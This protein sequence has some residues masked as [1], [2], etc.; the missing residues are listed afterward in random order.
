M[1]KARVLITGG[2]GYV[3]SHAV[4][5]Y[6]KNN[7][8]V[9]VID[10][11]IHGHQKTIDVLKNFGELTFYK[12]DLR[13]VDALDKIFSK[14]KGFE[15]VLHFAALCSVDDSVSNPEKYYHNNVLGS[16]NLL[17]ELLKNDLNKI[18][19]SSTCAV[20]GDSAYLPIDENHPTNPTNPYGD[21]KLTVERILSAY[22]KAYGLSSVV[23]RYFNVCG[24]SEEGIIGDAKEPSVHLMQNAV[25][26]ALDIE[27]FKLTYSP[28]ET[29]DRS[30]IRDYLDVID[31]I[32]A[33]HLAHDYLKHNEGSHVFNLGTGQGNS[34][35]EIVEKVEGVTGR[36]LPRDIGKKREGEYAAV[37]ADYKK[38]KEKLGWEPKRKL[39]DSVKSLVNWY[40]NY[41]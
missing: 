4:L 36:N 23:L 16:L 29:K 39:E 14:E 33:H 15:C 37:Y 3:G 20:Y 32:E 7:Y 2:A 6:L 38:V 28:V 34:V 31:L 40:K 8:E 1:K 22:Y 5:H 21:T 10:N 19:F 35:L 24:A 13:D 25:R 26:G 30:P 27:P 12:T 11:L 18:V 9:V 17:H 41:V